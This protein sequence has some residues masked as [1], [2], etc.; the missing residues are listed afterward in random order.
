MVRRGQPDIHDRDRPGAHG[1]TVQNEPKLALATAVAIVEAMNELGI[2]HPSIG[3]RWPNDL[4]ADGRKLGGILPERLERPRSGTR[5]LI[6]IGLNLSTNLTA[7]PADVR[8]MATSLTAV[9]ANRSTGILE[10]NSYQRFWV[11][12]D[13]H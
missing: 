10:G 3:I 2:G 7:A 6:G 12:L 1:L 4:E 11:S 13:R 8:A 5:V 9:S